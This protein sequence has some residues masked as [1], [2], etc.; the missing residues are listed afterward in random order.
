MKTRS[1]IMSGLTRLSLALG[2][3]FLCT[4]PAAPAQAISLGNLGTVVQAGVAY[5]KIDK[6]LNYYE[7]EGRN[8][9]M[10]QVKKEYGVNETPEANAMLEQVMSKLSGSI[11]AVDPS[12][13]AKPYNYF[14]N[15]ETSFNAFCT[16][17]HNLS[18]NIGAFNVLNYN[19]DELAV[20]IAH[21]LGHGQKQ[22]PLKGNRKSLTAA[23]AA[24]VF[25]GGSSSVAAKLAYNIGKAKLNTKPQ[26][27]EADELAFTYYTGAGYNIG[28]GAA[29]WERVLEK[30]G[31]STGLN[32][33]VGDLLND[34][35][36][37]VSRL[38]K[39]NQKI[40]DWSG[41]VVKVEDKTGAI[42]VNGKSFYAPVAAAG[43]SAKERAYFI[44]GNLAAVY[45]NHQQSSGASS[46]GGTLYVGEQPILTAAEGESV[47]DLQ[48]KLQEIL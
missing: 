29:V 36:T 18:V 21:E 28:A 1:K 38:A 44:A 25:S 22:H 8:E 46:D 35:P 31:Q 43:M 10:E 37:N 33:F 14:V 20:V 40:T 9:Y 15:N 39:Y 41:G 42:S 11:A 48:A 4:L 17:G 24:E 30:S 5:A 27:V 26:E 3:M 16:L 34:H 47:S 32:A 19:E 12:I 6:A 13:S 45:H 7:N 23:M 2:L